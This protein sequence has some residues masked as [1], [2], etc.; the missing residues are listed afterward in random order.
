MMD[1][2]D[3]VDVTDPSQGSLLDVGHSSQDS[4]NLTSLILRGGQQQR[5]MLPTFHISLYSSS[6]SLP[7]Y[8]QP[9]FL[10]IQ[11]PSRSF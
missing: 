5:I 10:L 3:D 7:P 6:P 11:L 2:I 4:H 8:T 1:D 9:F